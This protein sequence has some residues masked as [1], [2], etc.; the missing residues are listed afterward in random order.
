MKQFL[1]SLMC[2]AV[3]CIAGMEWP[4]DVHAGIISTIQDTG[5]VVEGDALYDIDNEEVLVGVGMPLITAFD[6]LIEIR[7]ELA[8]NLNDVTLMGMGVGLDVIKAVNSVINVKNIMGINPR[9][10]ILGMV[11]MNSGFDGIRPV[12][13]ISIIEKA[14]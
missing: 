12:G 3:L 1:I 6:D 10:G 14:F 11:D 9:I 13:Y 4:P 7:A 5:V 2:L 8:G